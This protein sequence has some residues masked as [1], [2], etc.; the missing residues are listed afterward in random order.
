[1]L[2]STKGRKIN[3]PLALFSTTLYTF[4]NQTH[5]SLEIEKQK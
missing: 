1:M 5:A 4:L 3:K 2:N